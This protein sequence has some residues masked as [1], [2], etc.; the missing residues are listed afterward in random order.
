LRLPPN[1]CA[2]FSAVLSRDADVENLSRR[3][4]FDFFL[5]SEEGEEEEGDFLRREVSLST[6]I[7]SFPRRKTS[8]F[9]LPAFVMARRRGDVYL[10]LA[11]LLQCEYRLHLYFGVIEALERSIA[12]L[13]ASRIGA[14][15][16]EIEGARLEKCI[17]EEGGRERWEDAA[18]LRPQTRDSLRKGLLN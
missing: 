1:A 17:M 13:T 8:T 15:I 16:F 12:S 4:T 10:I 9:P 11:A 2:K 5:T 6:R 18:P 3:E 7:E 14:P